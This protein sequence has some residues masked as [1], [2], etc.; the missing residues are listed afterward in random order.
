VECCTAEVAW[1]KG[2]VGGAGHTETGKEIPVGA[3]IL[4][5]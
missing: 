2:L 5:A 1:I 4:E 3:L